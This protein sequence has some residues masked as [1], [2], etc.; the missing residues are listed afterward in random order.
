MVGYWFVGCGG[1]PAYFV[2][3][4]GCHVDLVVMRPTY[5]GYVPLA[6][7]RFELS[8]YIWIRGVLL[9]AQTTIPVEVRHVFIQFMQFIHGSLVSTR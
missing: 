4:H 3:I 9:V 1:L 7:G 5:P 8:I 6:L 2:L